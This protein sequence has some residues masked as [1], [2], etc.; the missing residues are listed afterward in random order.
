LD[1]TV[2][3]C[4]AGADG[5]F[6]DSDTRDVHDEF[7][8]DKDAATA[9]ASTGAG[10]MVTE[11]TLASPGVI[12]PL[13]DCPFTDSSG[14][15]DNLDRGFYVENFPAERLDEVTLQ[16]H[17][18]SPGIYTIQLTAREGGY[19]GR[20]IGT[21]TVGFDASGSDDEVE[22]TYDFGGATVTEGAT[23][24]FSHEVINQ[25][26]SIHYDTAHDSGGCPDI[27]QTNGTSAPLDSHRRDSVGLRI[28]SVDRLRGLG[29]SWAIQGHNG[30]GF[31]IDISEQGQLVAMWFTYDDAGNQKWLI[32]TDAGIVNNQITMT[33]TEFSGPV[34]G[35]D[36]D[37]GDVVTENWGTVSFTF[38]DCRT[39]TVHYNST[40]GF[41][42]GVYDIVKI[43]DTE[44]QICP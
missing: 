37:P 6:F 8:Y 28:E 33:M 31:M 38:D 18:G 3:D 40:T 5:V 25:A 44:Q 34:F 32:G 9:E 21:K 12:A 22:G 35:P 29:G 27:T 39:G 20:L 4:P 30:E 16:Y 23:I 15:G 42:S 17:V 14:G 1:V 7:A 36:Y 19:D 13:Y 24:A 2:E 10:G 43:Y 41:G 11:I 26:G